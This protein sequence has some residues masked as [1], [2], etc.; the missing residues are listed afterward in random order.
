MRIVAIDPGTE[1]S[2]WCVLDCISDRLAGYGWDANDAV[3]NDLPRRF[4]LGEFSKDVLAIEMVASQ[5][6][7]V[8]KETF[9]TVWWTG[10]FAEQWKRTS[11]GILPIEIYRQDVKLHLCGQVRAKDAN[12]RQALIDLYGGEGGKA[13]AIGSKANPGP[14]YG[15]SNHVWSALAVAVTARARLQM[16]KAA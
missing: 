14:L 6:M 9:R 5:G 8:G 13:V 10:R 12:V 16:R 3:L 4:G 15:V 2:G 7:A 1:R 11:G